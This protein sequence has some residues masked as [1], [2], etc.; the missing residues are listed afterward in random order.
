MDKIKE[1]DILDKSKIAIQ[2]LTKGKVNV[3]GKDLDN[4]QN[5]VDGLLSINGIDLPFIIKSKSSIGIIENELRKLKRDSIDKNKLVFVIDYANPELTDFFKEKNIFFIDTVGN[6]FVN[7]PQL[8]L[9]VEGKKKIYSSEDHQKRAFQKTGLKLLYHIFLNPD[10]ISKTYREI[11]KEVKI[12]LASVGYILD[13]L[14]EENY[15]VDIEKGRR[16]LFN[17]KQLITKWANNYSENLRPKIHRGYFKQLKDE[18]IIEI[19]ASKFKEIG[20]FLG[21]EYA[22]SYLNNYLKPEKLTLYTNQRISELVK[23]LG[24]IP[25]NDSSKEIEVLEIFWEEDYNKSYSFQ[26]SVRNREILTHSILTYSDLLLSN[27]Y[28]G[29]ETAEQLLNYEI[30]NRFK[31]FNFQW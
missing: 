15:I 21:G 22:A 5:V 26:D 10:L 28:R 16:S 13:E 12:S 23:Q 29:I 1:I 4:Q 6:C 20:I 19:E 30:R 18:S 9:L 14:K 31:G 3:I 7:L 27:N 2:H 11:A 25:A 17:V 24:I 8:L